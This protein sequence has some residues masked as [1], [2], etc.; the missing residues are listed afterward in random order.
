MYL[1]Y[2]KQN[3]VITEDDTNDTEA[4]EEVEQEIVDNSLQTFEAHCGLL[5]LLF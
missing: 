4:D 3:C 2:N 1:Y 5:Q